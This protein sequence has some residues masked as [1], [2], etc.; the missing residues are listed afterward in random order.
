VIRHIKSAEIDEV[1]AQT[2][3]CDPKERATALRQL[4]PCHLR[5]NVPHI[6]ER[7]ME[8]AGDP[9]PGVRSNVL[10]LL[11]DGSP[12]ELESRVVAAI[13]GMLGD[14]DQKLRRRVRKLIGY[15]RRT[16]QINIL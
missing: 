2:Y 3:S 5:R 6:W 8:M 14:P 9:E 11:A 12:R 13:E 15:Y 7:V 10:H 4:C 1:L 16:G